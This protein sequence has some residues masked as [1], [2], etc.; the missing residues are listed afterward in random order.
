[1]IVLMVLALCFIMYIFFSC[2]Y[3]IRKC[4][5]LDSVYGFDATKFL[6]R[7]LNNINLLSNDDAYCNYYINK[8]DVYGICNDI[9]RI[10]NIHDT[11]AYDVNNYYSN[12][13]HYVALYY[14]SINHQI[15]ALEIIY[16]IY[17]FYL[18]KMST[19]G[20]IGGN[21]GIN[22]YI[23]TL[24]IL[25]YIE[26]KS[27][28]YMSSNNRLSEILTFIKGRRDYVKDEYINIIK[29]LEAINHFKLKNISKA[30]EILYLLLIDIKNKIEPKTE[31]YMMIRNI[32]K[33]IIDIN[34]NI[35]ENYDEIITIFDS[36]IKDGYNLTQKD[37][38]KYM[39]SLTKIKKSCDEISSIM[40]EKKLI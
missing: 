11:S 27:E 37:E 19:S 35:K 17:S 34:F 10:H 20:D 5:L 25:S 2:S 28:N 12:A 14:A 36:M 33:L 1:M 15:V 18:G 8:I 21:E 39:Y 13:Y 40:T 7:T 23:E 24:L 3:S 9:L 16:K 38:L 30:K 29:L 31:N 4:N 32:Q 26:S 6:Y 22:K